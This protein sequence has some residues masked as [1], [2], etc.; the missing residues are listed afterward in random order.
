MNRF[1]KRLKQI[2]RRVPHYSYEVEIIP[3]DPFLCRRYG[4]FE[5]FVFENVPPTSHILVDG[6]RARKK[7]E[8]ERE[9]WRDL[10]KERRL[11]NWSTTFTIFYDDEAETDDDRKKLALNYGIKEFNRVIGELSKLSAYSYGV[12]WTVNVHSAK[13]FP[14][15]RELKKMSLE[16]FLANGE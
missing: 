9:D 10:A 7:P 5:P 12:G 13:E 14:H 11:K 3:I 15:Y 16:E 6:R 4:V 8:Y 1:E 2:E